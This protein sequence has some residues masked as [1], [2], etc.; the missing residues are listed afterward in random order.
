MKREAKQWIE[1]YWNYVNSDKYKEEKIKR[2]KNLEQ[3]THDSIEGENAQEEGQV[4]HYEDSVVGHLSICDVLSNDGVTKLLR[5]LHSLP[6]KKFKVENYYKK[7]SIFHKYDYVHLQYSGSGY[8]YFAEIE[9]LEDKYIKS[10]KMT[11]AQINSYFALI[12]YY[13]TFKKSL[14]EESYNQFIYDNIR[15]L[16]SKDYVIWYRISKENDKHKE[17]RDYAIVEQMTDESFP[18]IC[19]HYITSFLYSEQ[20]KENLLIN[21]EYGTRKAPIDIDKLYLEGTVMAYYNKKLNYVICSDFDKVNYC[22]LTGNNFVPR[23]SICEYIAD[24]G[25]EFFYCFFGYRELKLFE[26]EFSRFS[27]G[28]KRIA[29]NKEFKKLL[30]KLQSVSEVESR[31]EKDVY[32]AFNEAWDFYVFGKKE[33]LKKYH[34]NDIAKYKKIYENNFSYLKI[35]SEINYTK[36]SQRL[37]VLAVFISVIAIIVSVLIA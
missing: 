25:N 8:G 9:L 24:Y 10:I 26:R 22:M 31:K 2:K 3:A 27:T 12:E 34:E 14:D 23:F 20:G 36:N 16:T 11:S 6:K 32:T 19:Q 4:D 13:F 1:Y 37:T 7:P 18:L 33:D 15:N 17:D 29:Y 30:N 28:R 21:M 35:L 5:K